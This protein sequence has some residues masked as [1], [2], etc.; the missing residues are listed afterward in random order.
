MQAWMCQYHFKYIG[1]EESDDYREHFP[2]ANKYDPTNGHTKVDAIWM[3]VDQMLTHDVYWLCYEEHIYICSFY[4]S[5]CTPTGSDVGR[6][7][8]VTCP[9]ESI[10]SLV[11]ADY[12]ST[13]IS[14]C[15]YH[16]HHSITDWLAIRQYLDRVLTPNFL[17]SHGLYLWLCAPGYMTW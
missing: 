8:F 15:S 10:A 16:H 13:S 3:T 2:C 5:A 1:W 6:S 12:S 11:I 9:R 17:G 7:W 14:L 4:W